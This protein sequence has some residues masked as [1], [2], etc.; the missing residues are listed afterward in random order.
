MKSWNRLALGALLILVIV[1]PVLG[2]DR[3]A[4]ISLGRD[5]EP[6]FCIVN[7]GGTE[8][9]SWNIEY[10]TTPRYVYYKLE[11]P[12]RTVILESQT[13]P[14]A[15]GVNI[16]R[17][18]VV[19]NGLN[20]GK[21]W[22][23]VE[24]WS[25]E[26]GNEA[27][28]EVT[29]YVCATQGNLCIHKF[30]DANCNGQLDPGDPPVVG[31]WLCIVTP[32]GD[33]ICRQTNG[34]GQVCFHGIPLGH[35]TV[36]EDLPPGWMAVGPTSYEVDLVSSEI[37]HV[38]FLNVRYDE[39]YGACCL[40]N[41]LC[42]EVRPEECMAQNGEFYGLGSNCAGVTCP[43]PGACCDL[44]TGE[45]FFVLE[46]LCVPP[47]VWFGGPCVPNNPCPSPPPPGACCFTDGT[48]LVLTEE[49]CTRQGGYLWV[50]GEDCVDDCPPVPTQNTTWGKIKATYR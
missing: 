38:T 21:Y 27:N 1:S 39:C 31:W 46:A 6:P 15:T 33:T 41:G 25:Y 17:N 5:P 19:P 3:D 11:D 40:P 2:Q 37:V 8:E 28:A 23:R 24:Y 32:E 22:V 12:T 44:A 35:Y 4:T 49:E 10:A 26:S 50:P 45:C 7:P 9:I 30:R 13:Y 48:C 47:L 16:T 18:W 43:Q 20:D 42:I 36:F 29:F 14:G 34:D